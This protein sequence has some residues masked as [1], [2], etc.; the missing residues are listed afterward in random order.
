MAV[1]RVPGSTARINA[2]LAQLFQAH[3]VEAVHDE[4]VLRFPAHPG[5]WMNGEAF[6]PLERAGQLDFRL[7][8]EPGRLLVESVAGLGRT[9]DEQIDDGLAAFAS[10]S[11]H[12]LLS[13]FFDIPPDHGIV[14]EEWEIGGRKRVVFVGTIGSRFACPTDAAGDPDI[15]FFDEFTRLLKAQSLPSGTHWLRLYQMRHAG[16]VKANEVLLDNQPWAELQDGM[17]AFDWP[18]QENYY[19]VRVFLVIL[20]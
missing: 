1:I 20:D 18:V 19:D 14:R 15:R 3:G 7:E 16:S 4:N 11:F 9:A 12:V 8:I 6:N 2:V 5:R 10:N 13:A 17:A